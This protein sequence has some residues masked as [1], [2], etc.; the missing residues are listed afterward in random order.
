MHILGQSYAFFY[1]IWRSGQ[2]GDV[3]RIVSGCNARQQRTMENDFQNNIIK[4]IP[5]AKER[6]HLHFTPEYSHI[7]LTY[8]PNDTKRSYKFFNKPYSTFT[9]GM[10][11]IHH[12]TLCIEHPSG[13]FTVNLEYEIADNEVKIHK[14]GVIRTARILSKGEV[15]LPI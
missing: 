7:H 15:F 8:N 9:S 11:P 10:P 4:S 13:E 12:S 3:T 5:I 6:F 14:S 2:T 1:H